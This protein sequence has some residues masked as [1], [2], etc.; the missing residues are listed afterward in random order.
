MEYL[1]E[2]PEKVFK[3]ES[4]S[5]RAWLKSHLL[6]VEEGWQE[7]FKGYELEKWGDIW[8]FRI[9]ES[10]TEV[11]D[12]YAYQWDSNLISCFTASTEE[13][14]DRTLKR[15]ITTTPGISE[16]WIR[17]DIF[18]QL[19]NFM[20]ATYKASIYRFISTRTR[21]SNLSTKVG[22]PD[23]N[24][25]MN[26]SGEDA[27]EVL[28]ETQTLYGT[29][30]K[31]IDFNV[32]GSKIQL[33]RDGLM[34]VRNVTALTTRIILEITD[35]VLSGEKDDVRNSKQFQVA[36]RVIGEGNHQIIVPSLVA[37]KIRFGEAKFD[38]AK[39]RTLFGET[40]IIEELESQPEEMEEF[41]FSF[42][43]AYVAGDDYSAT[44]VDEDK[45]TVFG[46]SGNSEE[47]VL[48]P[49]HRTTFESFVRFYHQILV[50]YDQAA[51]LMTF[52]ELIAR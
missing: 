26:Y 46:L 12:F 19:K 28:K 45:G 34:V 23:I 48:V 52:S 4:S 17:P 40:S 25:R 20:L 47:I 27:G 42:I 32:E 16:A 8:Y 37:G 35:R 36:T 1:V 29:L 11:A 43:D 18:E 41:D 2:N 50:G 7:I 14:Y 24:R 6:Y 10:A 30:P 15:L 33:N 9:P 49:K 13:R 38:S 21:Y 39:A 44:V 31:T 51:Q 22:R 3:S 5:E